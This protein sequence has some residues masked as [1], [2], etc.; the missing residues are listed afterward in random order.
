MISARINHFEFG[1]HSCS[2]E[3][4][5]C[6]DDLW[7]DDDNRGDILAKLD[8]LE[9]DMNE[10]VK[11]SASGIFNTLFFDSLTE[12]ERRFLVV[13]ANQFFRATDFV[14]TSD[15]QQFKGVAA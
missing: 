3:M 4:S 11:L 14:F 6:R 2:F 13:L 10:N 15:E 12:N 5:V 8:F 9:D 7:D 1:R